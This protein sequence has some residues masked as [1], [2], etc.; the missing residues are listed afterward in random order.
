[1]AKYTL[2]ANEYS[3]IGSVMNPYA[4]QS[5]FINTLTYD[6]NFGNHHLTVMAGRDDQVKMNGM[7]GIEGKDFQTDVLLN[8]NLTLASPIDEKIYQ[9]Y[10]RQ[11]LL[12]YF[13]RANYAFKNRYLLTFTFRADG[14]SKFG[15]DKK[16]GYFPAVAFAW[17]AHEESF[18]QNMDLFDVLKLRLSAGQTGN[19]GISPYQSIERYG[20]ATF[21]DAEYL[22]VITSGGPG[23]VIANPELQWE[24]T[25]QYNAAIETGFLNNR[26]RFSIESYF[27]H[28]TDLLRPKLLPPSGSFTS[29][30]VNDGVVDNYGIEFDLGGDFIS[31][32]DFRLSGDILFSMNRNVVVDIGTSADA[33]L[34]EENGYT[35]VV[36]ASTGN[37]I[38]RQIYAIGY[39]MNSFYGY[40]QD[41]Y[42]NSSEERAFG[43]GNY[44]EYGRPKY[45]DQND[46]GT[47][48]EADRVILGNPTPDFITSFT[49]SAQ[50]KAFYTEMLFN[51]VV[52][53]EL[54]DVGRK[55][56]VANRLDA[57]STYNQ[58]APHPIN[59]HAEYM[60]STYNV[61]DGSFFRFQNFTLG[62]NLKIPNQTIFK[63]AKIYCNIS[64]IFV[65]DNYEGYDPEVGFDTWNGVATGVSN[66]WWYSGE[67]P[68]QRRYTFGLNLTF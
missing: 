39:P 55:D 18:I 28:T 12:S 52:G 45:V 64:N 43:Q 11:D 3:G 44:T 7:E 22:A 14:S 23:S 47:I 21:W 67:W 60:P 15:V 2:R 34:I 42:I 24:T 16:W 10:S 50:Y 66:D 20:D 35:F 4:R 56:R 17:K 49:L 33:G 59:Q 5:Y 61:V 9:S 26:F 29:Q 6:K 19:Q 27:K 32:K 54:F 31:T 41:G 53:N 25:T 13:G 62:Y 46:D 40:V 48:D 63:R 8:Q 51:A 1:M 38:T 36:S 37:S 68:R 30:I 57:W 58:D 65:I